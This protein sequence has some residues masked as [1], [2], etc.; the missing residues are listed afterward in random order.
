MRFYAGSR[1]SEWFEFFE[2]AFAV[3]RLSH[4]TWRVT[5]RLPGYITQYAEITVSAKPEDVW[6]EVRI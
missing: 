3:V 5:Y 6:V 4:E 2:S 1:T